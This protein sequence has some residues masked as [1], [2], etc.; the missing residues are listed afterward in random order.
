MWQGYGVY[1][2]MIQ[3]TILQN[4]SINAVPDHFI[5][6][7]VA[8]ECIFSIVF[9]IFQYFWRFFVLF[10]FVCFPSVFSS[11]T[12]PRA[13]FWISRVFPAKFRVLMVIKCSF[14]FSTP[15]NQQSFATVAF[16]KP[17]GLMWEGLV[18]IK[19]WFKA[20]SFK[21]PASMLYRG[22]C[23]IGMYSF[24]SFSYVSALLKM[25]LFQMLNLCLVVF[26]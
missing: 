22:H 5:K 17:P 1:K 19:W 16:Y 21:I 2:M 11:K 12:F 6:A 20:P 4:S 15:L 7:I 3:S 10:M 13:I 9:P 8:S 23:C 24:K 14:Q 25:F 26:L 18:F